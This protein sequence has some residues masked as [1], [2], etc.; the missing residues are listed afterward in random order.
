MLNQINCKKVIVTGHRSE[1]PFVPDK[2][3]HAGNY[4]IVALSPEIYCKYIQ[5]G[6]DPSKLLII[7]NAIDEGLFYFNPH[8]MYPNRSAYVGVIDARKNQY[9]YTS[10]DS[11]YFI[12]KINCSNFRKTNNYLGEWT[13]QTLYSFLTC[14]ANLVL[15]SSA[16]CHALVVCEALMTGLGVVVSEAASGNLDRSKPWVTVIPN[17]KLD[18][19]QFVEE[20]IRENRKQSLIHRQDIRKY[21]L[22]NFSWEVRIPQIIKTYETILF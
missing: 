3:F 9:K 12:G 22:E 7:P 6:C 17:D 8:C 20:A 2:Q 13:K 4:K 14:F 1:L 19:I 15:L 18:D 5:Y 11:V 10:I 21:A 16:E